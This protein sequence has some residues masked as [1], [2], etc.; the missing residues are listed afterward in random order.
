[1]K[2]T[3]D[4]PEED[5]G[6]SP[7]GN[8][9]RILRK[10][11]PQDALIPMVIPRGG[12]PS[13]RIDRSGLVRAAGGRKIGGRKSAWPRPRSSGYRTPRGTKAVHTEALF[14]CL[15]F[16]V[17]EEQGSK[18]FGLTDLSLIIATPKITRTSRKMSFSG[19]ASGCIGPVVQLVPTGGFLRGSRWAYLP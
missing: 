10:S 14:L 5:V 13:G 7:W 17:G 12:R 18:T 11:P 15:H 2:I 1:M 4:L 3:S 8:I 16:S 6:S 19:I 9:S